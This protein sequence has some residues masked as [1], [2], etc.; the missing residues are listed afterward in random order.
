MPVLNRH[1]I[2]AMAF[3]TLSCR[4]KMQT[5]ARQAGQSRPL[6]SSELFHSHSA[7]KDNS[8]PPLPQRYNRLG[9]AP[10]LQQ[11]GAGAYQGAATMLPLP[12]V[13]RSLQCSFDARRVPGA[14]PT[15]QHHQHPRTCI[16]IQACVTN[17]HRCKRGGP[18][19]P[20]H[21]ATRTWSCAVREFHLT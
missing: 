6:E 11:T 5:Q 13:R 4:C 7:E 18:R 15:H 12:W 3:S 17:V 1:G 21:R 19:A 2:V 9:S 10:A 14:P 16:V 20:R 8:Q